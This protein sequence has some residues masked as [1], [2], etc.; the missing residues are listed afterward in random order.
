MTDP[1]FVPGR[2]GTLGVAN[3]VVRAG[4]SES[5]A[6]P[7][8]EVTGH[9][10]RL[11]RSLAEGGVGLIVTGH[12]YCARRG[13]YA[14]GQTG[15]QADALVDGLA[16][17]VDTVHA[18]GGRIVAQL[19]HAGSQSRVLGNE[20]LAP[21]PVPNPLTG[22]QVRAATPGEIEDAVAAF[23]AAARRAVAAGFDGVHI[24]GANGYLISE[25]SSP[26]TNRRTDAWGDRD[27]F[28]LSVVRA[29][30]AAVG[31]SFSVL[32]K[33]GLVDAVP[34]GLDLGESVARAARL[35]AEGV[36]ALE[37]SC[38]LMRAPTDSAR[39]YV[40]VDRRRALEDWLLHRVVGA[41][42]PEAYF[43]PW[44][45]RLRQEVDVPIILVGG[46]RSP[47]TMRA[48]LRAGDADFVALARPLI[49]EP[50]LV[51]QIAAGR[52]ELPDCTSCNLCLLHEGHHSLRC[53]RT[54]RRRLLQH[55]A[56]RLSGGFR[57][58]PVRPVQRH[59]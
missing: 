16:G 31:P 34:G 2:I 46:L 27:R 33:T 25:F 38:G 15:I 3:R 14:V 11:Y 19:A 18:A 5:M 17:L 23:A 41:P 50:D 32:F 35:V 52:E 8:G 9:L 48:L 42:G 21:S 20:P 36:D 24:H 10:R 40:A 13:R 37:V 49:R 12:L 56:Y 26:V 39:T 44:A 59:S 28:A 30:R 43:S 1:L 58:A 47:A 55:A 7:D 29:V 54:P 53:W 22:E 51:R 6:G 57:R 45:R 4:T